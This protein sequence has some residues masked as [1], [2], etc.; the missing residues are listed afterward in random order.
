M[1]FAT[2][3]NNI[4]GKGGKAT[5]GAQILLQT[6]DLPVNRERLKW[7]ACTG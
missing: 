7:A 1:S 4:G 3:E 5:K 2:V 6:L